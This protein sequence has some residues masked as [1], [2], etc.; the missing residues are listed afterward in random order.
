MQLSFLLIRWW[1]T[2]AN[3]N[4]AALQAII[5]NRIGD[6]GL[7]LFFSLALI[8]F[9]SWSISETSLIGNRGIR[10]KLLLIGALIAAAGK[11]AQF[12]LHPWLP[13]AM[14]GPTP[15]SALLHSST[16]VVAGIFLLIRISPIYS[17]FSHFKEWCLILGAITAIFAATTAISQHDIKKIGLLL[18]FSLALIS[19][20]SWSISETSLI[21]NRGIRLMN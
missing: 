20:N 8:S 12:G 18:F 17:K 9:N 7:L 3:A 14:E 15:V 1:Q 6:I 11:S 19:F 10:L 4:K 13:A 5:Y 21:G 16:M 2:R